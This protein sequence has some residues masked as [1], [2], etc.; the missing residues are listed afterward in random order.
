[1]NNVNQ[2]F[3]FKRWIGRQERALP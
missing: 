1:M 3:W 2:W